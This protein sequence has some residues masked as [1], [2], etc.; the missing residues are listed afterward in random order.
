VLAKSN[1]EV[2]VCFGYLKWER[3]EIKD[4][5][6][7]ELERLNFIRKN[8]EINQGMWLIHCKKFLKN[9]EVRFTKPAYGPNLTIFIK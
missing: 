7:D 3:K 9:E 8:G 4:W 1:C 6:P 2:F 5:K